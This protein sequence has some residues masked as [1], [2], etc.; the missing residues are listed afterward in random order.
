MGLGLPPYLKQKTWTYAVGRTWVWLKF[1]RFQPRFT[2][3]RF[4]G[5]G[6]HALVAFRE[7]E[8]RGLELL[9]ESMRAVKDLRV[10]G[11]RA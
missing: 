2:H 10:L 9:N 3:V 4:R 11:F 6:L 5:L 8:C 7:T 1:Q